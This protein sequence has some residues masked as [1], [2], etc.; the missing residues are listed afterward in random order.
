MSGLKG[1]RWRC[2]SMDLAERALAD[3]ADGEHAVH[4]IETAPWRWSEK[5]HAEVG[6]LWVVS[7]D[8]IEP[9]REEL[10]AK[11]E[12]GDVIE[13][14]DTVGFDDEELAEMR[15]KGEI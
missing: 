4:I 2:A 12:D 13:I 5:H 1:T 11:Y 14:L 8:Q 7:D 6:Q 9:L 3:I 15:E 10:S